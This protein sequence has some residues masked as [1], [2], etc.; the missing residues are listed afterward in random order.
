MP[1]VMIGYLAG[2]AA[3]QGARAGSA[4]REQPEPVKLWSRGWRR[5]CGSGALCG[6]ALDA[7]ELGE[8]GL[9]GVGRHRGGCK[10]V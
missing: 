8:R 7:Q 10:S 1:A 5:G 3:G 6:D 4:G 9:D 2:G